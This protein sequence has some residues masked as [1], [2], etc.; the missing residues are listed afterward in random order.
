MLASPPVIVT[1]SKLLCDNA[2]S[3]ALGVASYWFTLSVTNVGFTDKDVVNPLT[4]ALTLIFFVLPELNTEL[5]LGVPAKTIVPLL[6]PSVLMSEISIFS[7]VLVPIESFS[8]RGV[9]P[10]FTINPVGIL[11]ILISSTL[12]LVIIDDLLSDG[13]PDKISSNEIDDGFADILE[14]FGFTVKLNSTV[15]SLTDNTDPTIGDADI[16]NVPV[17]SPTVTSSPVYAT[18]TEPFK[19]GVDG[20]TLHPADTSEINIFSIRLPVTVNDLLVDDWPLVIA[21]KVCLPG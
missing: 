6:L 20:V 18:V 10:F 15:Y 12:L 13:D 7:V 14:I 8:L 4:F 2:I 5:A 19:A 1:L 3:C 9:V 11:E 16:L 21:F 17:F